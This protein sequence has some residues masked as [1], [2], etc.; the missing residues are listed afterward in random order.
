MQHRNALGSGKYVPNLP[1]FSSYHIASK[2]FIYAT[3][4][5]AC[6]FCWVEPEGEQATWNR[7]VDRDK[8]LVLAGYRLVDLLR[9]VGPR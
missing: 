3:R 8:A 4:T 1:R 6:R 5:I 9:S 7:E 2:A